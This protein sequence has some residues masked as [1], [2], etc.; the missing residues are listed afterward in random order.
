MAAP[1]VMLLGSLLVCGIVIYAILMHENKRKLAGNVGQDLK[2]AKTFTYLWDNFL[3][4]GTFRKVVFEVSNLSVYSA[5]QVRGV[6]VKYYTQSVSICIVACG[7][8]IIIFKDIFAVLLSIIFC[9]VLYRTLITKRIDKTHFEVLKEFSA[10]LSSIREAYILN[11]NIPDAINDC[12]KSPLLQRPLDRIYLIL[13]STNSEELLDD[14]YR[15]VP[16]HMLQT[17]AGVC[18]LMSDSGDEKDSTGQSAFNSAITLLKNECDAEVRKLTKQN[19]LFSKLEYLPLAPLLFVGVVEWFFTKYMPGTAT[20]YNGM[21]GQIAQLIIIL[22]SIISYWY[23]TNATSQTATKRDDR[24]Y[25]IMKIMDWRPMRALL[26]SVVP[27]KTRT[28]LKIRAQ[29]E[30]ALS[31]KDMRYLYASKICAAVL[32]FVF[33]FMSLAAFTAIAKESTYENIQKTSLSSDNK[34]TVEDAE[35]WRELDNSILAQPKAPRERDLEDIIPTY[36]PDIT[37]ME[38]KDQCNRIIAKYNTYHSLKYH[39][40]YVLVSMTF[41]VIAWSCPVLLLKQR[42]KM[43]LVEEEEDVLQLQTMLAVL[44]YTKLTT[45]DALY[46]LARQSRIYAYAL[47]FAYH[48]YPSDPE[49]ALSR[50]RDKSHLA[51]FKQI[52]ERLMS[53]ISQVTIREAFADLES[54]R[55]HM[56]RVREMVQEAT[57]EKRRRRCSPFSKAPL[58]IMIIGYVLTPIAILVINEG[59]SILEQLG[60]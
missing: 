29:V 18:Y 10:T 41:A 47:T 52:C 21:Y 30:G 13:T 37:T 27:K 42:K 44:R 23:I 57:I 28:R 9:L 1:L 6:A 50:L 40:W 39:W 7:L 31:H 3:T 17:L 12:Y 43:V 58:Y 54:E 33:T 20:V 4:R 59:K 24:S 38:L 32:T 14:Y 19:L 53:T 45:L 16:F 25:L 8:S 60:I 34:M 11:G 36:F 5:Q 35:K 48:E 49:L 15:T 56:I 51:E 22:T 46:W 55:A 26:D 2:T